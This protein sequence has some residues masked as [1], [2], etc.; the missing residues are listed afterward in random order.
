MSTDT[1]VVDATKPTD[2]TTTTTVVTETEKTEDTGEVTTEEVVPKKQYDQVFARAKTAEAE[3]KQYKKP[4]IKTEETQDS[5]KAYSKDEL[6][7]RLEGYTAPE[8]EF[9][10]RNGGKK[11]LANAN[12]PVA[13]AI[14]GMQEQRKAEHAASQTNSSSGSSEIEV[15]YTKEQLQNMSVKELEKILPKAPQQ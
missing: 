7:M 9:I 8:V 5:N 2:E 12:S 3:L 4:I 11:E 14:K 6:D 15:K 1:Q 13:I 10:M